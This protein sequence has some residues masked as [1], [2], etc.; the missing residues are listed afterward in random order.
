MKAMLLAAGFGTRLF[1][2]TLDRPKPAL[3]VL[4]KPLV[5]YSVEY[6]KS[7][8]INDFVVNLH[9]KG[10]RIEAAL[11]DG[12]RFGC[13]IE[14]SREDES[15]ILGTSGA[16]DHAKHLLD[17]GPFIV[18]NAKVITDID[19]TAAIAAHRERRALATLVLK[20]N[21]R[22]E[23][24]SRVDIDADRNILKFGSHPTAEDADEPLMFTGIQILD[25]EIFDYIPRGVFSHSTTDV[26]PKAIAEGRTVIAHVAKHEEMWR[27]F[28]TLRRYLDLTAELCNDECAVTTGENCVISPSASIERAI[29]WDNVT[30]GDDV[31]L[32][33]VIVGENVTIPAGATLTDT[34]VVRA[35]LV[36][37]D[38]LADRDTSKGTTIGENYHFP[39]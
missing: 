3:P 16:L 39:I 37:R 7:F 32:K 13:A 14:Y 2:L 8:G 15:G 31:T 30:I 1:P 9:Y 36:A 29:L 5:A 34:A 4:G 19:L 28:S 38:E 12:S 35:E 24:F 17:G 26:Y 20:P 18:M 33:N 27:E 23:R 6:L 10:D 21:P 25:P 22:R 11:G